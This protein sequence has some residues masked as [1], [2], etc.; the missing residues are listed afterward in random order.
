VDTARIAV[1]PS[2]VYA[3]GSLLYY[4]TEIPTDATGN[5]WGT[6]E[7]GSGGG[8]WEGQT[9]ETLIDLANTPGFEP[10]LAAYELPPSDMDDLGIVECG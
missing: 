2:G 3:C 4:L 5:L 9:S 7:I 10:G 6:L 8:V 1:A